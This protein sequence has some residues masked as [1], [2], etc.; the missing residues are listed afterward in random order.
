MSENPLTHKAT[1]ALVGAATLAI[2]LVCT[3]TPLPYSPAYGQ[4]AATAPAQAIPAN[5]PTAVNSEYRLQPNTVHLLRLVEYLFPYYKNG[6]VIGG[7]RPDPIP[8]HPSGQA[9]DIMM[10][11]DGHDAASV[12]DGN[13]I[14]AF[15]MANAGQLGID[16]L[17]W[18][19]HI[20]HPGQAWRQMDDRGNWT[21]NHMNHI[22]AKVYGDFQATS[23]LVLPGDLKGV[24]DS[25]P[26]GEA[27]RLAHEQR[28]A[29]ELK[30]AEARVVYNAAAHDVAAAKAYN[31]KKAKVLL[32]AQRTIN[33]TARQSYILGMDAEL[34]ARSQMLLSATTIDPT[35]LIAAERALRVQRSAVDSSLDIVTRTRRQ[36]A[37]AQS[38][39]AKAGTLLTQAE[40]ELKEFNAAQK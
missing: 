14:A 15:L 27:L 30:V 31:S 20:W 13:L 9:L 12:R 5:L 11:N 29:L 35:A 23:N 1:G 37:D 28:V 19:Q 10:A 2:A 6:G 26:D 8:D 3:T 21:D 18:R 24:A 33:G 4:P 40:R 38:N 17:V 22:H 25:L 34:L 39:L 16:Y 7:Y 36:L 32:R